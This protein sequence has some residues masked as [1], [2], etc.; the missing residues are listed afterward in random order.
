[1]WLPLGAGLFGC[2]GPGP[3][4]T[5]TP[6]VHSGPALHTGET[7]TGDTG[8][9]DPP[10]LVAIS[11]ITVAVHP[12][13]PSILV[14][15]WTQDRTA[16]VHLE[17]SV[18]AGEWLTS[19]TRILDAGP[20]RELVLGVPYDT[21]V[22]WRIVGAVDAPTATPET[23]TRTGPNADEVPAGTVLSA[24]P[25]RQDRVGAAYVLTSLAPVTGAIFRPWYAVVV[26]RRG[27]V[28]W[29]HRA[30]AERVVLHPKLAADR[31]SIYVDHDSFWATFDLGASS[32]VVQLT[33]EGQELRAIE[34]PGLHHGFADLPDGSLAYGQVELL[35]EHL[36]VV[37]PDGSRER[38]WSCRDWLAAIGELS[39]L[40]VCNANTLNHDPATDHL[41]FSF[42]SLETVVEID[43]PTGEVARWF[44]HVPGAYAFDPPDDAF[45]WQ[46]GATF[47]PT[48]TLLVST[49]LES[50][51]GVGGDG[52]ETLV[53]EY[54]VHPK[55]RTLEQVFTM[56]EGARILAGTMGDATRLP[57][58]NTLHDLGGASRLREGTPDGA[59]V[60]DVSWDVST[61][62]RADPI[63]DL[64][65]LVTDRY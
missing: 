20:H 27:R 62:G 57:N 61:I 1:M 11:D 3:T 6:L 37:S 46:H 34:T 15:D 40:S 53:R 32:S 12:T 50:S 45:W 52:V 19:P 18:D 42:W 24:D 29:S 36:V 28:V 26:D 13:V 59:I 5:D 47:T 16:D 49:D 9:T 41:L 25:A 21:D 64:Y 63:A 56:D 38:L 31:Q 22:T 51:P 44:G 39:P 35:D 23:V 17:F 10:E 48:G 65:A 54:V 2:G 58:G 7:T 33:L 4:A 60:W 43:R 55:T 8:D 30:P 14:V